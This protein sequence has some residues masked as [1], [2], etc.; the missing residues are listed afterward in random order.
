MGSRNTSEE[1]TTGVKSELVGASTQPAYA[2]PI[3]TSG[4][5]HGDGGSV[6]PE[7]CSQGPEKEMNL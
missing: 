3:S 4:V 2:G 6:G 7:M 5:K 1:C